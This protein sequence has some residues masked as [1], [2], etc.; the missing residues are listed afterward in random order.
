MAAE[1]ECVYYEIEACPLAH[2]CNEGNFKNCKAWGST[3]EE[4]KQKVLNH[5]LRSGLH[6]DAR[7]EMG[8]VEAKAHFAVFVVGEVRNRRGGYYGF[9]QD[10]IAAFQDAGLTYYNEAVLLTSIGSNAMRASGMFNASRKL[11]KGHQ[12]VLVFAKGE[13]ALSDITG[14]ARAVAGHFGEH[15]QVFQAFETILVF[16]KGDPK[17]ATEALGDATPADLEALHLVEA[18]Q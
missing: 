6:A 17:A 14:L 13:P 9:V 2:E 12:N 8:V 11:A 18:P 1:D 15:R 3:R 4:A 7:K 16:C 5:L 10:T